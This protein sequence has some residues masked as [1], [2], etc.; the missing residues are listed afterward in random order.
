MTKKTSSSP[1]SDIK[2]GAPKG[3]DGNDSRAGGYPNLPNRLRVQFDLGYKGTIGKDMDGEILVVPDMH[4][5]IR[6]LLENHSRGLPAEDVKEPL[7]FEME[8]PTLNDITDVQQYA[9]YLEQHIIDIKQKI[10]DQV[11][12]NEATNAKN[13]DK[14]T[15]KADKSE[16]SEDE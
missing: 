4:L 13:D 3:A 2:P 6:Q 1:K 8:V 7:Y 16:E 9:D 10:A 14:T 11:S 5:T 12:E 15:K